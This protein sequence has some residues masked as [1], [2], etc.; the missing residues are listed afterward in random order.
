MR[1]PA[2]AALAVAGR[3]A[4]DAI[5]AEWAA[6]ADFIDPA[7][8]PVTRLANSAI[9]GVASNAAAVRAEILN[10]A[11]SDLV[12]YRAGDPGV[13]SPCRPRPG[14]LLV[15]WMGERFGARFLFAEGVMPVAQ[16]PEA[17]AAVRRGARR[18]RPAR[19][20]RLEHHQHADRLCHPD[21][22]AAARQDDAGQ[23][24]G[25]AVVDEDFEIS[26]WGED[27]EA[28]A[29]RAAR[30]REFDAAALVLGRS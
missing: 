20:R 1:T 10:Y 25:S 16:F 15:D 24:G 4:A 26:L 19:T 7:T 6:Q 2:K 22:G 27:L 23:A 3:R 18:S 17:I 14:I 28:T 5:V 21:A 29:R 12:C 13:W 8:M 11:G 9:D 30:R